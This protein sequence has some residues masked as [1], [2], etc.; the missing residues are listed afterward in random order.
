MIT[1]N[2]EP[3]AY[4]PIFLGTTQH[5][6]RLSLEILIMVG[7]KLNDEMIGT[8]NVTVSAIALGQLPNIGSKIA[9]DE[10]TGSELS[11]F[12]AKIRKSDKQLQNTVSTELESLIDLKNVGRYQL[13]KGQ[14]TMTQALNV[15]ELSKN[16]LI[17]LRQLLGV[18]QQELATAMGINR[19][20]VNRFETGEQ[21]I[22]DK[23]INKLITVYPRLAEAIEVQFDW[24]SLTF[25]DLTSKQVI[26]DVLSIQPDLFLERPTSQNFYTRE[27]AFAGEKNIYIQ[28]FAPIKNPET[29]IVEQKFGTTLYLTGKGT[30]LF[31]KA[32]LEQ[33]MTWHDFFEKARQYRGHLTRLDIA[34][35]DKWGL[36]DMNELVKAV[37]EKRF[38]SKSKSYAVHGNVDDGWTVNF[39]KS[40]FVIRAYDKH[41]EQASKGFDTDVQNRV[42]L[43]LHQD[44]AEYVIDGWF[45]QEN[46]K[47]LTE[48]TFDILYTHLWFTDKPIEEKLLKTD[49]VRDT[50]ENSVEPM[51]A[52]S[53]LTA[54]GH[55][56]KFIRQPKEQS[57]ERIEKWVLDSV[58]PSLTVLK[59]TG[60][61][62]EVIEAMNSAELSAEQQKLIK[63]TMMNAITQASKHLNINF[64]K[65][66]K[67]YQEI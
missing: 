20:T 29:Q 16:N 24:V 8:Y 31:E 63:S 40:P 23:F 11:G 30:R 65:P 44:K 49:K 43:E 22:S 58:V 45:D 17:L 7:M 19:K 4:T 10:I 34:I 57:V 64:E 66:K 12:K 55:K 21:K 60:H 3:K 1:I 42:E 47:T 9:I 6:L 41:K 61:W 36:L 28:D 37:Q 56:M 50:I 35:N 52:W 59:K 32:L 25:P 48:I 54:L 15:P 67:R 18:T 39:G 46:N 27:M 38:W 51:P 5:S 53:L 14:N 33:N 2:H 26:N 13:L 62:A